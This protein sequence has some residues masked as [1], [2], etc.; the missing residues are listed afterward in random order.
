MATYR[1]AEISVGGNIEYYSEEDGLWGD[2]QKMHEFVQWK[3]V[4]TAA[5]R[6]LS[7]KHYKILI[8]M[9]E[10][11]LRQEDLGTM[12]GTSRQLAMYNL[13]IAVDLLRE[14]FSKVLQSRVN[15]GGGFKSHCEYERLLKRGF[16]DNRFK[17]K[18]NQVQ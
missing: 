14:I 15:V 11:C 6:F 12:M 17:E 3:Y 2:Y 7:P 10:R 8:V 9:G 4:K 13:Q 1:F 18:E 5:R 16:Y